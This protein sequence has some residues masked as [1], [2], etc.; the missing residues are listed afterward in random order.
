MALPGAIYVAYY[1]RVFDEPI[2]L[3]RL[4][5]VPGSELLA[6][7]AGPLAAITAL[8]LK[9]RRDVGLASSVMAFALFLAVPYLKS[10]LWPLDRGSLARQWR[11][12]VCYQST[13]STCG[14][15]SAATVLRQLGINV[16][17]GDL[18]GDAFTTASGTENWY[19]KRA[20]EKRGARCFYH[21]LSPPFDGLPCPSIAGIRL[22][23]GAGHFV[24]IL[25]D[26]GSHYLIG[27]PMSGL[28]KVGKEQ[29]RTNAPAFSGFFMEVKR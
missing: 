21:Y 22:G 14:L 7:L 1:F 20:I 6:A 23:A 9:K 17:E 13:P 15:A 19:L 4:R 3:Y 16:E 25:R 8:A 28:L 26:T 5:S 11:G 2:W 27:D 10:W 12:E 24:A 29:I 18:A